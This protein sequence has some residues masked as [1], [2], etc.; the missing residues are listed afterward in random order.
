MR[1]RKALTVAS[2]ERLEDRLTLSHLGVAHAVH[3]GEHAAVHSRHHPPIQLRHHDRLRFAHHHHH[4]HQTPVS[5]T[6]TPS[7]TG[8]LPPVSTAPPVTT[9]PPVTT[10]PPVGTTPPVT[11]SPPV[12]T[13]PPSTNDPPPVEVSLAGTVQGIIGQG[14]AGTVSPLGPGLSS[15][16]LTTSGTGP[17]TYSGTVTVGGIHGSITVTLFGQVSSSAASNEPVKLTYEITGGTGVWVGATGS[18][19]AS[20]QLS[21]TD[22]GESFILTFGN[23]T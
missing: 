19:V 11:T 1:R 15:V 6:L 21:Q 18:G 7:S 4:R 22:S 3:V 9:V 13:T 2:V 16:N 23:A 12:G 8:T 20:L 14:G 10:S 17:I 5:S